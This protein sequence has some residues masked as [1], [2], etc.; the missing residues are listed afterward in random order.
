MLTIKS[1]L[2]P[3][4]GFI[5]IAGRI[6]TVT[7]VQLDEVISGVILENNIIVLDLTEVD[8]LSSSAF[9]IFIKYQK[10]CRMEDG[11]VIMQ[12]VQQP[13]MSLFKIS[14][15]DRLFTFT[16]VDAESLSL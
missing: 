11:Q 4:H 15:F 5:R 7:S 10:Q 12:G 8:Y 6:D 14:G 9:R 13:L 2:T 1:E 16:T 3:Q